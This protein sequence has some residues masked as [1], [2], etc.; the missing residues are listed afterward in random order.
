VTASRP[1]SR[2]PARRP[3]AP[4][5]ASATRAARR[6]AERA[7]GSHRASPAA[8]RTAPAPRAARG[9]PPREPRPQ[10]EPRQP[11]PG[12]AEPTLPAIE[13]AEPGMTRPIDA[14]ASPREGGDGSR[15][16]RDRHRRGERGDRPERG[17]APAG[18]SSAEHGAMPV[19]PESPPAALEARHRLHRKCRPPRWLHRRR[20]RRRRNLCTSRHGGPIRPKRKR[21]SICPWPPA[22]RHRRSRCHRSPCHRSH[23]RCNVAAGVDVAAGGF[24]TRVGR[25]AI[26]GATHVR[27][28]TGAGESA[29]RAPAAH[30]SSSRSRCRSSR[31]A[32]RIRRPPADLRGIEHE[33]GG[34]RARL[35]FLGCYDPRR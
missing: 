27:A 35:L 17:D 23:A 25:D 19:A 3:T 15:R 11:A 12:N 20:C 21:S 22:L 32:R 8:A 7:K 14:T 13:A 18:T 34:P 29:A 31:R 9:Q 1:V 5:A 33:K 2:V 24:R 16:R 30:R 4:G 10:R 28:R 6:P 26:E